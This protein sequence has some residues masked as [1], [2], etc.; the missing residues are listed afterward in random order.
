[1]KKQ[2]FTNIGLSMLLIVFFALAMSVFAALA[3]SSAKSDCVLSDELA[4]RKTEYYAAVSAAEEK[5][6]EIDSAAKAAYLASDSEEEYFSGLSDELNGIGFSQYNG[7]EKTLCYSVALNSRHN[8]VVSLVFCY[9]E[10]G[11]GFYKV[12][13][14]K[15][16]AV[17]V[18]EADNTL[19]L[20]NINNRG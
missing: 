6:A 5:L 9:P 14:Y 20:I 8:L 1:M 19:N 12:T 18:W 17:T 13:A 3:L 16:E 10:T 2:G 15:S 7:E 4:A 11:E